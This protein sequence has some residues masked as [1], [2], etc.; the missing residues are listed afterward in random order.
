MLQNSTDNLVKADTSDTQAC[1]EA[2]KKISH[3]LENLGLK[4]VDIAGNIEEVS[5]R[6]QRENENFLQL[7]QIADD[8]AAKNKDVEKVTQDSYRVTREATSDIV[9]LKESM[10][11]SFEDIALLIDGVQQIGTR[12]QGLSGALSKI[13]E[14][15]S[16]I[17]RIAH[18]TNILALNATVVAGRA[19][20]AGKGFSIVA[21]EV[22]SLAS[23]TSEATGE[24]NSTLLELE[25]QAGELTLIG[26]QSAE[27]ATAV[28]DSTESMKVTMD[29]VADTIRKVNEG[30]EKI[31]PA[32]NHIDQYCVKTV[33][34]LEDMTD[35]VAFSSK[36][37]KEAEEQT[38]E[39]LYFVEQMLNEA[40]I[41]GSQTNE[42]PYI[43]LAKSLALEVS[44]RFEEG[45][46]KGE[47]RE[48]DLFD[49]DYK[50]IPGT[51]P[52]QFS[53]RWNEFGDRVLPD[54]QEKAAQTEEN[55]LAAV[56]ADKNGYIGTHMK[57]VSHSQKPDDPEWN[58]ANCRN[59][60]IY[61]DRVGTSAVQNKN[62]FL[63]QAYRRHMGEGVYQLAIDVS[64]PIFVNGTH[65]GAVRVIVKV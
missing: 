2:L 7:K 60:I 9:D 28:K 36:D 53:A 54:F 23:Q 6:I 48:Q 15:A 41:E 29:R 63:I 39:L 57:A 5:I 62:P 10:E 4:T 14:V 59:R 46:A 12:I 50:P 55:V 16:G 58:L 18:K 42:T 47:I 34:G 65:W 30:S 21:E 37:L 17:S 3:K 24:I 25:K 19:G 51:N 13:G 27:K 32:V 61:N 38:R 8:L 49:M 33:D 44:R 26:N 45:I 20:A 11:S 35:D 31:A 22:K 52:G 1:R 56:C 43:T 40:N 64:S